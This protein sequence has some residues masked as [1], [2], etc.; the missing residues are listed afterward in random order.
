M[1]TCSGLL[2]KSIL[3]HIL[4]LSNLMR[5]PAVIT[6]WNPAGLIKLGS[7]L[8]FRRYQLLC[9]LRCCRWNRL[10]SLAASALGR[11]VEN[12]RPVAI[13]RLE[14]ILC[15]R[16]MHCLSEGKGALAE[17]PWGQ[18]FEGRVGLQSGL[19]RALCQGNQ[20]PSQVTTQVGG[21]ICWD[22]GHL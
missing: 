5:K 1:L 4:E 12:L 18:V 15:C 14:R 2:G 7:P 6:L 17:E 10:Q 11:V 3:G 21:G 9:W 22:N 13:G 20:E 8:R 19:P 16:G